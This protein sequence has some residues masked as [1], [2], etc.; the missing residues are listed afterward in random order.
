M[1]PTTIHRSPRVLILLDQPIIAE[2][3]ALI[4]SHRAY[5]TR[6]TRTAAEVLTIAME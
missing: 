2:L 4:L 3:R 5:E 6:S 1:H